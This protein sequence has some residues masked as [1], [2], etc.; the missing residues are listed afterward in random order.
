M[1]DEPNE[2]DPDADPNGQDDDEVVRLTELFISQLFTGSADLDAFLKEHPGHPNL[3]SQLEVIQQLYTAKDEVPKE[4]LNTRVDQGS[5]E[6]VDSGDFSFGDLQKERVI[7]VDCPQCGIV[8]RV[9]EQ[10]D[11]DEV[12]CSGCGSSIAV[13]SKRTRS[14]R[15]PINKKIGRFN[16]LALVGAG[17]FGN[18]YRAKDTVLNRHVALKVPRVDSFNDVHHRSRFIREAK[19]AAKLRH[20]NI[21]Q[22]YEI[23]DESS[24]PVIVTEFVDGMTLG[25]LVG[26][27]RI[28]PREAAKMMITTAEAIHYAHQQHVI[29]RD[30]KPS[31]ILLDQD[32]TPMIA[33]FGLAKDE[34]AEITI[35]IHG[36]V[37]GT[38][39]YMS[40][41]QARGE[42]NKVDQRT[43]VYSLGVVMYQMLSGELPFR[44][45]RRMLLHQLLNED[46]K[47]IRTLN[48][49]V[50]RELDTIV[51]KAMDKEVAKRYDSAQELADDL[52]RWLN[53]EPIKARPVS[54]LRRLAKWYQRKPQVAWLVTAIA[55]LLLGVAIASGIWAF[56]ENSNA[57]RI[58]NLYEINRNRLNQIFLTNGK[59]LLAQSKR[60]QSLTWFDQL[61]QNDP[62][63]SRI[64]N[65]RLNLLTQRLPIL[66]DMWSN[67]GPVRRIGYNATGDLCYS[68][69]NSNVVRVR[70]LVSE[71]DQ[72]LA[73]AD[74]VQVIEF[75]GA[76]DRLLTSAAKD[77][78]LWDARNGRRLARLA[79]DG[80]VRD[81]VFGPAD[82]QIAVAS[83]DGSVSIWATDGTLIRRLKVA[84]QEVYIVR[85]SNDGKFLATASVS[86]VAAINE[87]KLWNLET[88]AELISFDQQYRIRDLA[89]DPDSSK[90]VSL[91]IESPTRVWSVPDGD[92]LWEKQLAT[93]PRFVLRSPA[94]NDLVIATDDQIQ[95]YGWSDGS[96]ST[97][98]I[99]VNGTIGNATIDDSQRLIALGLN[100]GSVQLRAFPQGITLVNS[101]PQGQT[102]AYCDLHPNGR[103][104]VT[105]GTDGLVKQ[106]DLAGVAP[107]L[108]LLQHETGE[109]V[110]RIRVSD[111]GLRL[112]TCGRDDTA[113]IWDSR[114]GKQ[115]GTTIQH[116][117]DVLDCCFLKSAAL[118][119]TVSVDQTLGIWDGFSGAQQQPA[120][121]VEAPLLSVAS[122]RKTSLVTGDFEGGILQ[123]DLDQ[124]ESISSSQDSKQVL[125]VKYSDDGD[126]YVAS[127]TSGN[128]RLFD[129]TGQSL[130]TFQHDQFAEDVHIDSA[131]KRIITS[132]GV[133]SLTVWSMD[134]ADNP[135]QQIYQRAD[136][137]AI[138]VDRDADRLLSTNGDGMTIMYRLVDGNY[139]E[140]WRHQLPSYRLTDCEF[141]LDGSLVAISGGR[142]QPDLENGRPTGVLFLLDAENGAPV[143]PNWPSLDECLRLVFSNGKSNFVAACSLDSTSQIHRLD[144]LRSTE[145]LRIWIQAMGGGTIG[146]GMNEVRLSTEQQLDAFETSKLMDPTIT[147]VTPA[148]T[149]HW[150]QYLEFLSEWSDK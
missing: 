63:K 41:E 55:I 140:V 68:L 52:R 51:A 75:A 81:A 25:D 76:G 53:N 7:D 112:L 103:Q 111:D 106:W 28:E 9:V 49:L 20:A 39:A 74:R 59:N 70:N 139:E 145:L 92:L 22:V 89:F 4:I 118:V 97:A 102:L 31:N 15:S 17:G 72:Q 36:E 136:V 42:N 66:T 37:L 61:A 131:A 50:P 88:G 133:N 121:N 67:D 77:V 123:W 60:L 146:E 38:P 137:Y 122:N 27:R 98:P 58:A 48:D 65:L 10:I 32:Q 109:E 134:D 16:I 135:L 108:P 34:Q 57:R 119:A 90:F 64:N 114:T 127:S 149:T 33:D 19:H 2:I 82:E 62:D 124:T 130:K 150:E 144:Q 21:V 79:H 117:H 148:Q 128:V 18:V 110:L 115:L 84:E 73:H 44:G 26:H 3:R 125:F 24:L 120:R 30:I 35:T 113:R 80:E 147:E 23:L 129:A 71:N 69:N 1:V 91:G 116:Q 8:I 46:P 86:E 107:E 93:T 85:I 45:S 141:S 104:L 54:P 105:G 83:A 143:S 14:F 5:K 132:G 126:Y 78:L 12:T 138:A 96:D 43:D 11:E 94:S 56:R 47:P 101:L 100:D 142:W 29:H 99:R 95:F 6:E 87:V 13:D 40:P